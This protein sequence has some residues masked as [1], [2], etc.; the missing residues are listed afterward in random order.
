MSSTTIALDPADLEAMIRRIVQAAVRDELR[1]LRDD[2]L[3]I[4]YDW[5]HEGPA[6]PEGDEM[7]ARDAVELSR[8]YRN[9]P[10]EL[11]SLEAFRDELARAEEAGELSN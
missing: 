3:A 8:K 2:S 11:T 9:S 1:R 4:L 5:R 10:A 6:D 7:L